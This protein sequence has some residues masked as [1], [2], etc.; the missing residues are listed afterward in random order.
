VAN[1]GGLARQDDLVNRPGVRDAQ[2]SPDATSVLFTRIEAARDS[3]LPAVALWRVPFAGGDAQ[4]MTATA[5]Q[6][7]HPRWT[8]DGGQIAFLSTP[9][10]TNSTTRIVSMPADSG[11][12]RAITPES[13]D[14]RAFEW[15]PRG[16]RIAFVSSGSSG[17]ALWVIDANGVVQRRLTT[18]DTAAFAW[19]PDDSAIA[20]VARDASG[21][22]RV[23]VVAVDNSASPRVIPVA[24][25]P[26]VSW[27]RDGIAVLGW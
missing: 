12:L 27:S 7:S 6:D 9:P 14:V 4:R 3:T 10:R 11:A 23:E 17:P 24:V 19:A 1:A 13:I 2:I 15:S 25:S 26:R 16:R 21:M 5:S 22:L 18:G 20:R 8:P